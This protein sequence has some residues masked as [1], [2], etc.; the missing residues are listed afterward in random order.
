MCGP[1][2]SEAGCGNRR[3]AEIV[4]CCKHQ[5]VARGRVLDPMK[6]AEQGNAIAARLLAVGRD[7]LIRGMSIGVCRRVWLGRSRR[8]VI[9][10]T[11]I[12][13]THEYSDRP[14]SQQGGGQEFAMA[15]Q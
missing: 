1:R 3:E 5:R 9:P 4:D 11:G 14:D 10:D 15:V 7:V 13:D 8:Y 12:G 2:Q 6:H